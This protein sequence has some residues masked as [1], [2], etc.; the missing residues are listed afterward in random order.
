MSEC[1]ELRSMSGTEWPDAV[2]AIWDS[3]RSRF[4]TKWADLA[5]HDQ[6][7]VYRILTRI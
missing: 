1:D 5:H 2:G 6:V 3:N 4:S 7:A